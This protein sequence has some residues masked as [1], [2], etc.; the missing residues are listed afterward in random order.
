MVAHERLLARNV[1]L[2][3]A[4][5]AAASW[6]HARRATW[7]DAP[8]EV[9]TASATPTPE[10]DID[11]T[12]ATAPSPERVLFAPSRSNPSVSARVAAAVRA[13]GPTVVR[14]RVHGT[15]AVVLGAAAFVAVRYVWKTAPTSMTRTAVIEPTHVGPTAEGPKPTDVRTSAAGRNA[16]GGLHVESTPAG[17]RVVVDAKARGVTPL[18]LA[19][20][21]PGRH[22]VVLESGA[23]TVH[24]T[25]EIAA[26]ETA[27]MN[28]SIFMGWLVVYAPFEV[29]IVEGGRVLRPDERNQIMLPPGIHELRLANRELAYEAVQRVEVKPGEVT[30]LR[31]TPPSSTLT[32]TAS[33]AADVWLDGAR[34]GEAPLNAAPVPLGTHEVVVKREAGGERRFTV[35]IGA[36][37]FTLNVDFR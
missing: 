26:N 18:T 16:T 13:F 1:N 19:G 3:A 8:L 23:G 2:V 12:P 29:V 9:S 37:P 4:A 31:L 33:E 36:N 6:G 14:W 27:E 25:V 5:Q 35:T 10:A 32:V 28:E 22:Q 20:L 34:L 21:T 15:V 11:P 17:A 7:T 30:P 24:R